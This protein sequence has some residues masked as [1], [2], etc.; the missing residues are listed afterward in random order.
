MRTFIPE[1]GFIG[2]GFDELSWPKPVRPNDEIYAIIEV[3]NARISKSKPT[4]GILKSKT[5][6]YNQ[7]NEIVQKQIVNLLVPRNPFVEGSLQ[8]MLIEIKLRSTA[9]ISAPSWVLISKSLALIAA[10]TG[11]MCAWTSPLS[12]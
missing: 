6:T 7:H 10:I 11:R 2:A 1:C 12:L 4:H 5:Y 3:I 9:S 8:N